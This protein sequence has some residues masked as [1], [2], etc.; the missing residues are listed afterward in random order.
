MNGKDFA[1]LLERAIRASGREREV[2]LI[3]AKV[4]SDGQGQ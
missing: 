4:A 3:E 2:K 1:S